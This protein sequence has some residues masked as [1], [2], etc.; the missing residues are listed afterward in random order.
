MNLQFDRITIDP[1]PMNGQ[2]CIR[3]MRLS[4]RR[5]VE[6]IALVSG[7]RRVQAGVS[8]AGRRRQPASA[9]VRC[10]QTRRPDHRAGGRVIRLLLD[11]RPPRSTVRL[12]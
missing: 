4:V 10:Q 6:V 11:R 5:V 2:P 1:E 9:A 7:S 8:G 3:G 12:R